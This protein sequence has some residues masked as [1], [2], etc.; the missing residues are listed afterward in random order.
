MHCSNFGVK[1][2]NFSFII[3]VAV[4][5]QSKLGDKCERKIESQNKM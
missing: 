2:S 3:F 5:F 4:L 1:P